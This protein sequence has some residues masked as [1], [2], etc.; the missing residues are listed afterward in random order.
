MNFQTK[1]YYALYFQEEV[2]IPLPLESNIVKSISRLFDNFITFL[3]FKASF[4]GT[5]NITL[6]FWHM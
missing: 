4:L 5:Q 2:T 6:N 3:Q 1:Y